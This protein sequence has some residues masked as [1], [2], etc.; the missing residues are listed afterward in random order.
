MREESAVVVAA[1]GAPATRFHFGA[2]EV[3]VGVK[4]EG[5]GDEYEMM[6]DVSVVLTVG[7]W[8]DGGRGGGG[9]AGM[10]GLTLWVTAF[11][12]F[13]KGHPAPTTTRFL[14]V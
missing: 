9:C 12:A 7:G 8:P 1:G 11:V 4:G 14:D 6:L 2:A 5:D 13:T 10:G 3:M